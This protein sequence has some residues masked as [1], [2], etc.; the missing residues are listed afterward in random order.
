ME[1]KAAVEAYGG[2]SCR[3]AMGGKDVENS[4]VGTAVERASAENIRGIY[5][6]AQRK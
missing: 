4:A 1:D 3:V 5:V 2:D 6:A